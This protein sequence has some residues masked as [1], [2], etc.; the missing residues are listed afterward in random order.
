MRENIGEKIGED[1]NPFFST[2]SSLHGRMY[3]YFKEMF[4]KSVAAIFCKYSQ[5][6]KYSTTFTFP[7]WFS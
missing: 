5:L 6:E 2:S 7:C 4:F 3:Q 1:L